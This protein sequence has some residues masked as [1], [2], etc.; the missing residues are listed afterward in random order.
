MAIRYIR[1]KPVIFTAPLSVGIKRELLG[2]AMRDGAMPRDFT[3]SRDFRH[4]VTDRIQ[5]RLEGVK[6]VARMIMHG[7]F[8]RED[9][10]ECDSGFKIKNQRIIDKLKWRESDPVSIDARR[11]A[12]LRDL[13][14]LGQTVGIIAL[15]PDT[16]DAENPGFLKEARDAGV[17]KS[18]CCGFVDFAV[19]SVILKLSIKIFQIGN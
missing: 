11:I 7:G 3:M 4:W 5:S 6:V 12:L 16:Y 13:K 15:D 2:A 1:K 18:G 19:A 14:R 9:V 10:E 8:T 17:S